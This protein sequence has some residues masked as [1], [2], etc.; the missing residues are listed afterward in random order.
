M[1]TTETTVLELVELCPETEL[2]FKHY[3]RT[4]GIC[5]CCDALFCTLAEVAERYKIDSDELMRRLNS[6]M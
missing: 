6:V 1:I 2:V 4:R 3:T 5:I